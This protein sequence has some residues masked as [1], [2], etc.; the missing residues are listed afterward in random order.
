[1]KILV[2]EWLIAI[3]WG[4]GTRVADGI[5]GVP[6]Q[7]MVQ[8]WSMAQ[9]LT[10]DLTRAGHEVW[11]AMSQTAAAELPGR[12][13][14]HQRMKSIPSVYLDPQAAWSSQLMAL[15]LE[16]TGGKRFDAVWAIAPESDHCLESLQQT[17]QSSSLPMLHPS[18]EFV[19]LTTSK[20]A[21]LDRLSQQ[22][23]QPEFGRRLSRDEA[24]TSLMVEAAQVLKLDDSAGSEGLQFFSAGQ[25][26]D[27][28]EQG[29]WRLE[30]WLSGTSVSLSVLCG[31][32]QAVL[33][34]PTQQRFDCWP[35]GN[36][37]GGVFPLDDNSREEARQLV[38]TALTHLPQVNG[39][40]GFDLMLNNSELGGKS[41]IL[42]VNPRLTCSYLGLRQIYQENLADI[43]IRLRRGEKVP[44]LTPKLEHLSFNLDVV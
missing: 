8:G 16:G 6:V 27:I 14:M 17:L 32:G 15:L 23:V 13:E 10:L 37:S 19:T 33:L 4:R 36:Y 30:P 34:E 1:M 26:I 40:V 3:E 20:T 38:S 18:G 35:P 2:L 39:Y 5:W 7:T 41:I 21:T 9:A 42:E 25:R 29:I 22:K 24:G 44:A 11:I 12:F 28:P 43:V 31:N